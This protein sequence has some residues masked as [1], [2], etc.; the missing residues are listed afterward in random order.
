MATTQDALK[1][2]IDLL[3]NGKNIADRGG[4]ATGLGYIGGEEARAELIAALGKSRTSE[5]RGIIATALGQAT[6]R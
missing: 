4:A 2:L 3:H 5:E 1:A 6:Q